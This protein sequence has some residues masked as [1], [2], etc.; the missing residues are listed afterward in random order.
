M[1]SFA[2]RV[3]L[4]TGAGRGIGRQLALDLAAEGAA[5][6]ALDLEAGPLEQLAAALPGKRFAWAT[7]DV[8]NRAGLHKAVGEL[9]SKLGPV[10]LLI[11]NAGIG[12]ENSALDFR[13]EDFEAQVQ[14][15][16]IGVANSVETV[17]PGMIERRSGHLVGISSLAS[18]RGMPKMAGYCASKAGVSALFDTLRTELRP[19]GIHC[20]TICP[21]FIQTAMT[22][23]VKAD[24]PGLALLDLPVAT[25]HMLDAVRLC[26]PYVAF[27]RRSYWLL[28]VLHMLPLPWS[29]GIIRRKAAEHKKAP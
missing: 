10:E 16:L 4:I 21:G 19:L 13:A 17:L 14:V 24:N 1:T 26:R 7:A 15:N 28:R 2:N 23:Q 6:A 9:Q 22:E 18:L 29:D 20:T 12:R 5:I 11:A 3:A 8:T 27:P 25:R